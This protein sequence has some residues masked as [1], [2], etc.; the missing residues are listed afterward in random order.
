[1][2]SLRA[3]KIDASRGVPTF[4]TTWGMPAYWYR[5]T[6]R[7]TGTVVGYV[8]LSDLWV[9]R[10]THGKLYGAHDT[11]TDAA[12][13]LWLQWHADREEDRRISEAAGRELALALGA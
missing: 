2:S 5:V 8:A 3:F 13:E 1:M 6:D 7:E 4:T 11:R 10:D 9:A 12:Y